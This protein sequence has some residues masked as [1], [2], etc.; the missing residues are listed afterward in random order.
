MCPFKAFS[1]NL[2]AW[3]EF[4]VSPVPT[5]S[6]SAAFSGIQPRRG[7]GITIQRYDPSDQHY[8]W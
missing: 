5:Y 6:S 3:I 2:F 8:P 1:W 7:Q 4:V